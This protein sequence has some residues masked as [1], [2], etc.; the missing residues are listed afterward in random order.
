MK[1]VLL[2]KQRKQLEVARFSA[3]VSSWAARLARIRRG[4]SDEAVPI[5]RGIN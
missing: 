3:Q 2:N 5:L 1:R 4:Y